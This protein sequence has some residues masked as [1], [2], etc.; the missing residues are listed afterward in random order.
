MTAFGNTYDS[1]DFPGAFERALALA[2][3]AGF[4]ARKKAAKKERKL[5][6]L[7]IGC[8]LEIAGAFP[9]EA[10]RISFPGGGKVNVSVGAGGSGQGHPTVFAK[11]AARRLGLDAG[12]GH[13]DLRQFRA[14]RAR[15]RRGRLALGHVCR[16]R[17]RAH[18]RCRDREG[19]ARRRHAAAGG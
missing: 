6:G 16:R 3:Y 5:R 8:Y 13:G 14:R 10:A 7:G 19:Q 12:G 1:G 17:H 9:E 2:D 18:G 15:L 4:A 11:V